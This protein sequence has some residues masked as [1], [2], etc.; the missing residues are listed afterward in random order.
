MGSDTEMTK[1]R[2]SSYIAKVIIQQG[3]NIVV[4]GLP[5]KAGPNNVGLIPWVEIESGANNHDEP[6]PP[7]N[8]TKA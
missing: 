4:D 2:A 1:D 3:L 6:T 7:V 8:G 5:L